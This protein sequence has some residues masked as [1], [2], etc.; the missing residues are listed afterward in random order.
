MI[1]L[2]IVQIK[3]QNIGGGG[4]GGPFCILVTCTSRVQCGPIWSCH[5]QDTS[6]VWM[7]NHSSST[8]QLFTSKPAPAFSHR[9]NKY[10]SY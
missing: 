4:G 8:E 10:K 6:G 3:I 1:K 2:Q 5:L 9:A 7:C